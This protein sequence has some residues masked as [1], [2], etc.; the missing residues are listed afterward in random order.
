MVKISFVIIGF[1]EGKNIVKAINSIQ[2]LKLNNYE[3]IYIDSNSSDNS[4]ELLK[5]FNVKK[6]VVESNYHSAALARLVGSKIAV[7]E[8]IFFLDGDMEIDKGSDL[9]FCMDILNDNEY[10]VI[11]G[12]L[13][14]KIYSS[15]EI[16][17]EIDDRYSVK[18]VLETLKDPGGYFIIKKST[19]MKAGNFNAKFKNNEEIDLFSRVKKDGYKLVRTNKLMCIHNHNSD[20]MDKKFIN[21]LKK[22]FYRDFWKVLVSSIKNNY[23]KEYIQFKTQR[24]TIRSICITFF[25]I[26]GI[27]LTP[28]NPIFLLLVVIYYS[29]LLIKKNGDFMA[30][31]LS[32]LNN[33]MVIISI[34]YIF[35]NVNIKYQVIKK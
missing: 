17:K 30:L 31:T 14:E 15:N 11:S 25:S 2:E 27:F 34:I 19:L 35:E 26:I 5:Q 21:R 23:I 33:V 20:S 18:G 10:G 6:Y 13:R 32:Q 28:I 12:K 4:L 24:N 22:R 9:E 7:G 29:L 8:Y 3:I 1:N 16:I